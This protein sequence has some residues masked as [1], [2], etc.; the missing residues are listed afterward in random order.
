[1]HDWAIA[2]DRVSAELV[3]SQTR[4]TSYKSGRVCAEPS[5]GTH[6]SIYNAG[7]YCSLHGALPHPAER[8]RRRHRGEGQGAGRPASPAR[9]G[10]GIPEQGE[11]PLDRAS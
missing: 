4:P 10:P 8:S 9:R 5:C 11:R 6:L 7:A 2:H 1:M 3:G